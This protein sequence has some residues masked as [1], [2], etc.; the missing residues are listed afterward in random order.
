MKLYK[1]TL[2]GLDF[3]SSRC[4]VSPSYV[5]ADDAQKA[6]DKVREWL[7]KADYGFF[8]ERELKSIELIAH[9]NNTAHPPLFL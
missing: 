6:Y 4:P 9:E 7:D 5:I 8:K 1:V 3:S 2:T